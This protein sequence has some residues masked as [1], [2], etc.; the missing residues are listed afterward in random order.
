MLGS[1]TESIAD[2][3]AENR[4]IQPI[5]TV[6]ATSAAGYVMAAKE[7]W[8]AT[9][10]TTDELVAPGGRRMSQKHG[11]HGVAMVLLI[12]NDKSIGVLAVVD[13]R[14]RQFTDDEVSLLTAF[15]DQAALALDK[16]RLL[17]EAEREKERSDSLYR[18]SNLLA[19]ARDTDEVL[20]LIVNEAVRLV[21]TSAAYIRLL[22]D[23]ALVPGA[24]TESAAAWFADNTTAIPAFTDPR[25]LIPSPCRF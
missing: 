19:G 10:A 2:Y 13:S 6:D 11:V 1:S 25:P 21:G 8:T 7:P 18:V 23:G 15:A 4:S 9:D 22:V 17:N 5:F 14:K 12:A 24:V 16:A 20:D 3:T